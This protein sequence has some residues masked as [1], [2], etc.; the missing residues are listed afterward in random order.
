[1]NDSNGA[2]PPGFDQHTVAAMV[3]RLAGDH[4]GLS[5]RVTDLEDRVESIAAAFDDIE[6]VLDSPPPAPLD[7]PAPGPNDQDATA[8][9]E[10]G[11][12]MR[13]LVGWVRDNVALLL[14]RKIP[15]TGGYPYWCRKWWLHPEAIAR[16]EAARRSWVE[17]VSEP[18][19]NAL[20]VYYEHLDHQLNVLCGEYGPFCGCLGG[21]HR[22]TVRPL[23]QDDPDEDYFLDFEDESWFLELDEASQAP[24]GHAREWPVPLDDARRG[25]APTSRAATDPT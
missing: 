1:M 15:Q 20:V 10:V 6:S 12:D 5:A 19:G 7:A 2:S 4:A 3:G 18:A 25:A 9:A 21:E 23:G 14:E 11:L 24:A 22:T 8:D 13:R 16:F 17:A